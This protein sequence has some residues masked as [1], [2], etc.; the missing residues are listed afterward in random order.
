MLQQLI[1]H[2]IDLGRLSEEGYHIEV[3]GG[4]L[5]V[6][7]IPYVNEESK[8][9]FGTLVCVLTFCTPNRLGKPQ[10]HTIFFCGD[11]PC[12]KDG[13]ALNSIINNSNNQ[14]LT[15]TIIANHY[16]SSKPREGNYANY[17]DKIRTYSEILSCQAK[18][19]DNSVTTKP[20]KNGK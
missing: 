17:Y 16:F 1:S 9:N 5:L 8:I 3:D 12:D 13:Q 7:H 15:S 20:F 6:H 18:A 14:Q 19:L 11:K 2:N 4:Y 10:D